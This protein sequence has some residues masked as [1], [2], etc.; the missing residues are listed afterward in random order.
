MKDAEQ[1]A[2][3]EAFR[4]Q[5][6][7]AQQLKVDSRVS[8]PFVARL[9]LAAAV[10]FASGVALGLPQGS[11]VAG[12]RYRA[13]NAHRLPESQIGWYLYHKSKNYNMALGGIK[14]GLR[15]GAKVSFWTVGFFS[16]EEMLDRYRDTKDFLNTVVASLSTAGGFS[17]WNRFPITTAA[18]TAK[19]GLVIGL[20][21]GFVQDI[22]GVARGRRPAYVDLVFGG[23]QATDKADTEEA[24]I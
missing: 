8:L 19:S 13:E 12:L 10:S 4:L 5:E 17:L 24:V 2:E 22:A 1:Q 14:E 9:P 23:R 15:M 3:E 18:R 7:S 20:A 21:Y 11:K 16:I 6:E